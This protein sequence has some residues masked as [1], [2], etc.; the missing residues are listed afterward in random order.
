MF[1]FNWGRLFQ[2]LPSI[3]W[4]ENFWQRSIRASIYWNNVLA[5][6]ARLAGSW[7]LF[8]PT[9]SERVFIKDKPPNLLE[10]RL[11][12]DPGEVI[13]DRTFKWSDRLDE[14]FIL[15]SSKKEIGRKWW[16]V[17][18]AHFDSSVACPC[19]C[20]HDWRSLFSFT[21]TIFVN[22][23]RHLIRISCIYNK[24]NRNDDLWWSLQLRGHRSQKLFKSISLWMIETICSST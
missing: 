21:F 3:Y 1:Q 12:T 19:G 18:E 4:L 5:Y 23:S 9:H 10:E 7:A 16:S 6:K 2:K 8:R 20:N 11:E 13:L 24:C 14:G 17:R 22:S 15:E